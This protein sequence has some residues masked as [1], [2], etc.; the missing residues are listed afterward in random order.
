MYFV[1]TLEEGKVKLKALQESAP[2]Q[3]TRYVTTRRIIRRRE[4]ASEM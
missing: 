4:L 3:G 1:D 2:P